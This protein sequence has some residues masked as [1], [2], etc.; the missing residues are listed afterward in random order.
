ML[1]QVDNILVDGK[2]PQTK[3]L[4]AANQYNFNEIQLAEERDKLSWTQANPDKAESLFELEDHYLLYGRIGIVGLERPEYFSRFISLFGCDYDKISCALLATGDYQQVDNNGWRWQL[5]STRPQSW[6][7][8]F[9]KSALV[10]HFDDTQEIL[11]K[12][13]SFAQIFTDE[14][15]Q[16]IIDER[17]AEY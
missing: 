6:Q 16:R 1:E 15:L 12:L 2:I 3:K 8:L 4:S 17:L 14:F 11:D 13:L 5:G 7:N 10:K 9:H